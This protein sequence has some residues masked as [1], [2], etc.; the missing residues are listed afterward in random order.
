MKILVL[1]PSKKT[2][3]DLFICSGIDYLSKLSI[4]FCADYKFIDPKI[5]RK[6]EETLLYKLSEGFFR[7]ALDENGKNLSSKNFLL[8]LN[9]INLSNTKIC[10]IVG[11]AFGLNKEFV[12][13]C[14]AQLSLSP[15]TMPHRMAFLVLCEQLF[16]ASQINL[17]TAYHK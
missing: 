11:G 12:N 17:G 15:M 13:N 7:V 5:K 14:D 3:S 6:E 4:P 16:R 10:F 2:S 9:K 8:F 1:M